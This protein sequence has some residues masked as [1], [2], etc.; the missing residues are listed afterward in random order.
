M[1]K[2][3][4]IDYPFFAFFAQAATVPSLPCW[5]RSCTLSCTSTIW[6][7]RWDL[8]T[9]SSSGGRNTSPHSKWWVQLEHIRLQPVIC[10]DLAHRVRPSC[11]CASRLSAINCV[12]LCFVQRSNSWRSS[13]IS[14]SCCGASVT[15]QRRLWCGSDCTASC[16]CFCSVTFTSPSTRRWRA[17]CSDKPRQM[18]RQS[19]RQPPPVTI[20]ERAW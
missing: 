17:S 20:M 1:T 12:V 19:N 16:S 10:L 2:R 14:S 5:T 8:N 15:I 9:R 6:S 4:L 13:R 11:R 7:R 18:G 3:S